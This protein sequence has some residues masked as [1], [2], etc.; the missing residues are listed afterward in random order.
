MTTPAAD[1]AAHDPVL[2]AAYV[3]GRLDEADLVRVDG[4]L[5]DC[6]ACAELRHD[7]DDLVVATRALPT[8]SR[9]RD[10]SLSPEDAR[11]AVLAAGGASSP[12]SGRRATP[13]AGPWPSGSPRSG[14]PG[15]SSR[16][17]RPLTFGSAAGV[18]AADRDDRHRGGTGHGVTP[19]RA[20]TRRASSTPPASRAARSIPRRR[21]VGRRPADGSAAARRQVQSNP[22]TS[23]IGE[24]AASR[25]HRSPRAGASWRRRRRQRHSR[26]GPTLAVLGATARRLGDG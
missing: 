19:S 4:W 15:S 25:D 23:E 22:S 5:A 17:C 12:P 2:V 9:P 3:D 20:R 21:A 14:S 8:P 7:L 18:G 11:R 6:G 10:F 24:S 16:T 1:H 26:R 13:S